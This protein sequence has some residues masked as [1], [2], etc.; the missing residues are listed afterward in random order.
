MATLNPEPAAPEEREA[1]NLPPKSFAEAV[2]GGPT[3]DKQNASSAGGKNANGSTEARNNNDKPVKNDGIASDRLE[4]KQG[5]AQKAQIGEGDDGK[6]A[7][8]KTGNGLSEEKIKGDEPIKT[9]GVTSDKVQTEG[10]DMQK[11]S[12]GKS[13]G[14]EKDDD[15]KSYAEVV[16]NTDMC[17]KMP[18]LTLNR[19]SNH[20]L[21]SR[22]AQSS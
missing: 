21:R 6:G 19:L 10:G 22:R 20:H 12:L 2:E 11:A 1:Q 9:E 18:V 4:V 3:D 8:G 7:G 14:Y 5:N 17:T 13:S 15:A 16:S